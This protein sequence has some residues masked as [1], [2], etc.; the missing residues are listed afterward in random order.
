MRLVSLRFGLHCLAFIFLI[1]GGSAS[2]HSPYLGPYPAA[3]AGNHVLAPDG[4]GSVVI[5]DLMGR[6]AGRFQLDKQPSQIVVS[7]DSSHVA[8]A[9]QNGPVSFFDLQTQKCIWSQYPASSGI[10]SISDL[11]FAHDGKSL[12]VASFGPR[13]VLFD[14]A[15]GKRLHTLSAVNDDSLVSAALSPDGSRAAMVGL[16]GRVQVVDVNSGRC[17]GQFS[18]A[19]TIRYSSDGRFLATLSNHD[20]SRP[21]LRIVPV[22]PLGKERDLGT[23]EPIARIEPA[24]DGKFRVITERAQ[25]LTKGFVCDPESG[26]MTPSWEISSH[27]IQR[28]AD[29]DPLRKIAVS[30]DNDYVT[31]IVDFRENSVIGIPPLDPQVIAKARS[32]GGGRYKMSSL[33]LFG[34]IAV[35][36]TIFTMMVA[37]LMRSNAKKDCTIG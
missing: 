36:I 20:G 8:I 33:E 35:V 16:L 15:T 5:Y 32:A 25:G 31:H 22:D 10:I 7:P 12:I 14:A 26:Q 2:G 28:L 34:S 23:R 11:S 29:F 1:A 3:I 30:T 18:G 6:V 27:Y 4:T 17:I 19:S 9:G 24:A 37:T 21:Y 13:A